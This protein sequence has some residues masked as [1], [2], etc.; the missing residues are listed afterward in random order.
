MGRG[1]GDIEKMGRVL[2]GRVLVFAI[3][4]FV[5]QV[6]LCAADVAINGSNRQYALKHGVEL[7]ELEDQIPVAAG[8]A[9][10]YYAQSCASA[11]SIIAGRVAAF[12]KNDGGVAAGLLRLFFHDCFVQVPAALEL[13]LLNF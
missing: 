9:F 3:V 10:G 1:A 5:G 7:E 6:A 4:T 8:L 12:L 13:D 11:E 2:H